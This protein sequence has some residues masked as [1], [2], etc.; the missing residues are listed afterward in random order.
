[1]LQIDEW[2]D[3][4]D[5]L[6]SG[7]S[8]QPAAFAASAALTLQTYFVGHSLSI[9]D[10]CAWGKLHAAPMWQKVRSQPDA[11]NLLRWFGFCNEQARIALT[12]SEIL[13]RVAHLFSF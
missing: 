3:F 7:P 12:F 13:Y 9:A 6:V 10:L 1:M 8:L 2:L 11:L 4:S 5:N